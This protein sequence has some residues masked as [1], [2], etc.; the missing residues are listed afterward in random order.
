MRDACQ[1]RQ[2]E[3]EAGRPAERGGRPRAALEEVFLT[4]LGQ[5]WSSRSDGVMYYV[6]GEVYTSSGAG[7]PFKLVKLLRFDDGMVCYLQDAVLQACELHDK[8]GTVW[9]RVA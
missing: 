3:D 2:L 9:Q 6:I 4:R 5:V 1:R 8:G 7:T